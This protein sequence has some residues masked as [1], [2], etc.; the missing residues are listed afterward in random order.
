[1]GVSLDVTDLLIASWEIG[2][3]DARKL[4]SGLEPARIEGRYLVSVV[5]LGR[6]RARAA[7]IPLAPFSQ[8]N[9]RTYALLGGESA[10]LFLRSWVTFPGIAVAVAGGPVGTARIRSRPGLL[11]AP[12][13]GIRIHYE[14]GPPADSGPLGRHELGLHRRGR[15]RAFTVRR[16][17]ADWREAEPLEARADPLLSLGLEPGRPPTLLYAPGMTFAIDERP[18]RVDSW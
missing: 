8:I 15:L 16:G 18:R 2:E 10:V 7:G 9:L 1:V 6:V 12:G 4:V 3:E 11:E 14:L 13:V 5:G 17:P